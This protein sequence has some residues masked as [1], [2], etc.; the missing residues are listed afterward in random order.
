MLISFLS[1]AGILR[2]DES[3]LALPL[4]MQN[5]TA[6]SVAMGSACASLAPGASALFFNPAGLGFLKNVELALHHNSGLGDRI[7]ETAIFGFDA[8]AAGG[9]GI[10]I[11]YVNNG[12]F[13]RRDDL[14]NLLPGGNGAGEFGG[15]LGWGKQML[16]DFYAGVALKAGSK[17][18]A[19]RD[20][21]SIAADAGILWE[22]APSLKIGAAYM[23]L[24]GTMAGFPVASGF[25]AGASYDMDFGGSNGMMMAFSG[26]THTDG[27]STLNAGLELRGFSIVS[28]R[29]GYV[30]NFS[31]TRFEGLAGMTAGMGVKLQGVELD[32]AYVPFGDLG[33][34]HR[35]SLTYAVKQASTEPKQA[36]K[37]KKTFLP[38][39]DSRV[40]VFEILYF[41]YN[42][43]K[44]IPGTEEILRK[45]V[46]ILKNNPGTEVLIVGNASLHGGDA[47]NQL[48]SEKRAYAIRNFLIRSGGI[49]AERLTIIGHGDTD[50]AVLEIKP[51]E[52]NSEAAKLNR[53][54]VFEIVSQ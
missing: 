38:R 25:R 15:S 50:P 9:F 4:A 41:E 23:N 17:T 48:L 20:Y 16:P 22:A 10:S 1:G 13:E 6:R 5:G 35:V 18:L 32:Y 37:I 2:A 19:G 52:I 39:H 51:G 31:D 44:M 43:W 42:K 7:Q 26:E 14:G 28:V 24:G 40:L 27:L 3:G 45:S 33:G 49:A 12:V 30:Y 47:Y 21:G 36:P 34:T 54:A 46:T 29:L 11:N 53:R 8:G